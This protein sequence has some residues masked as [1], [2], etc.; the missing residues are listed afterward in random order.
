MPL[1]RTSAAIASV[2][3]G[4]CSAITCDTLS[5]V[6]ATFSG[7]LTDF[8]VEVFLLV[9]FTFFFVAAFALIPS[10]QNN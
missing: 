3:F 5:R 1:L 9:F 8:F 10:S 6:T 2:I 7:P 4:A